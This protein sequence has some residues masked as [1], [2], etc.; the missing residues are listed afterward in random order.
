MVDLASLDYG[1]DNS[2]FYKSSSAKRLSVLLSFRM[3]SNVTEPRS[4]LNGGV[5]RETDCELHRAAFEGD[6]ERT[7]ELLAS[8][9]DPNAQ[10]RHGG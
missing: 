1:S 5:A 3:A 9:A 10:D 6:L 7:R 8:Q 2:V 4:P